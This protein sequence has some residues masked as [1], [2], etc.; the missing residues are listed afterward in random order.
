[1]SV[2]S[3]II[4]IV[5]LVLIAAV[6]SLSILLAKA[7]EKIKPVIVL[8]ETPVVLEKKPANVV[9]AVVPTIDK[10][11]CG[12]YG[13]DYTVVGKVCIKPPFDFKKLC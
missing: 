7:N 6:I 1:M 2:F 12:C 9:D 10:G 5:L 11:G 3:V 13:D 8:E 4:V